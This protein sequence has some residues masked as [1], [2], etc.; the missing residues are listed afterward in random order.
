MSDDL[1]RRSFSPDDDG[2]DQTQ[3][4]ARDPEVRQ[5]S[6]WHMTVEDTSAVLCMVA[7]WLLV[8]F[9]VWLFNH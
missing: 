4:L 5:I 2:D 9:V 1:T 7:V 6:R 3:P 8:I